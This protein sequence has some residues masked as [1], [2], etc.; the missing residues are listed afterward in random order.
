M[1]GVAQ[2]SVGKVSDTRGRNGQVISPP[3]QNDEKSY[4]HIAGRDKQIW[5]ILIDASPTS[6]TVYSLTVLGE[7]VSIISSGTR[8]TD[9]A[10]FVVALNA[11]PIIRGIY[12]ATDESTTTVV[13]TATAYGVSLDSDEVSVDD[14]D[15]AE[16]T[17]SEDTAQADANQIAI[18]VAVFLSSGNIQLANPSASDLVALAGVTRRLE[19]AEQTTIAGNDTDLYESGED[20][21][22]MKTCRMLVDTGDS[23]VEGDDIWIE[24]DSTN[25]GKL[26]PTSGS[27]VNTLTI[28]PTAV[29][30]ARYEI[31]MLI[32]GTDGNQYLVMVEFTADASATAT[33]I[34]TGLKAAIDAETTTTLLTTSGTTTLIIEMA[35]KDAVLL[36]TLTENLAGV[37]AAGTRLRLPLSRG[38]WDGPNVI[39]LKLGL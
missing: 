29:N 38:Q 32:T 27:A 13:L 36:T 6:T 1:H 35:D 21:A 18:G 8:A 37:R 9:V 11:N 15:T 25:E 17:L 22:V 24:Q 2:L 31:E 26:Y 23:A 4:A 39:Q 5:D 12:I 34:V 16:L 3:D 10:A 14:E 19:A 28:T 33:E 30:D 20:V 7:T